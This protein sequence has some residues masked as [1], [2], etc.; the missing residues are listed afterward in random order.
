M[1]KRSKA[2][3]LGNYST[4]RSDILIAKYIRIASSWRNTNT[5]MKKLFS[6]LTILSVALVAANA[7]EQGTVDKCTSIVRDFRTM[8]EKAIP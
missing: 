6:I 8:P 1:A 4:F 7:D 5:P 2:I 3:L